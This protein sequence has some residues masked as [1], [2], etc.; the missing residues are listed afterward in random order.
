MSH[1]PAQ[2][3][4][5][6]KAIGLVV[7]LVAAPFAYVCGW[8][9]RV[10]R[11]FGLGRL[12]AT[13]RALQAAGVLPVIHH[14]YEPLAYRHDLSRPLGSPRD[15]PGLDLNATEQLALLQ[16]FNYADE[17]RDFPL[18]AAKPFSF[19][20]HNATFGAGDA[21]LLYSMVRHFKP[22]KIVEIGGGYS[23]LMMRAAI[24]KNQSE[25]L[26]PPAMHICIE[27]FENRWLERTGAIVMRR[28]VE[29]VDISWFEQLGEKDILFID[30]S[31]VIRPQGD[32]L[33]EY[34]ELLGR[35]RTGVLVHVHD[36]FTP[37]DYPEEWVLKMQRLWNEQYLLE[38]FLSFNKTYEVVAALN[39]LWHEHREAVCAPFPVLAQHR[40]AE[41]GSFWI[42]RI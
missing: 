16:R 32:V 34:L 39:Y 37:R 9:L 20:Y 29:H 23:T 27:P 30:S 4:S 25:G 19:F 24:A 28:R 22:S 41:P 14:Y 40:T 2:V 3:R 17:L 8:L 33:F 12:P 36:I 38:A 26:C 1:V 15:V 13:R 11:R 31:H 18:T 6:L 35:L 5:V 42:R 21:E 7:D 10:V